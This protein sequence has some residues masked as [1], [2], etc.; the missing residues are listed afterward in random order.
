MP[1]SNSQLKKF[2][3]IGHHLSPIVIIANGLNDNVSAEISRALNDHE[4]IKIKVP[5]EDR[6]AKKA[7]IQQVCE[8]QKAELVQQIGHMA[9]LYKEA[10][11]ANPKLSNIQRFKE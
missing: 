10:A 5:S 8:E 11:S 2:R 1:L 6:E 9:L 7:L 3:S 4:L